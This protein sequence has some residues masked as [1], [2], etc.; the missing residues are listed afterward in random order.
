MWSQ[1]SKVN[2][3][4]YDGLS[5]ILIQIIPNSV[6]DEISWLGVLFQLQ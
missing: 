2:Y 3:R 4:I 5:N 6:T 1:Y